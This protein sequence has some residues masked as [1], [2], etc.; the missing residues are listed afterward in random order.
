MNKMK[1]V[2]SIPLLVFLLITLIGFVSIYIGGE[3]L[4]ISKI[5][6]S[7]DVATAVALAVLAFMAYY[8]YGEQLQPISIYIEKEGH[9]EELPVKI[10]RKNFSRSEVFGLLGALDKESSFKISYT[11]SIEFFKDIEDI[12]ASK[13]D[14]LIIK[15]GASDKFELSC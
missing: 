12:Q 13:K 4:W 1:N 9:R 11:S 3:N 10:L 6:A 8:Q 5:Y 15:L 7:L 14:S 2:I